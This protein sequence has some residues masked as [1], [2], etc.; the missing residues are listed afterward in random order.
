MACSAL[1][2]SLKCT[3]SPIALTAAVCFLSHEVVFAEEVVGSPGTALVTEW[4]TAGWG[5]V[6]PVPGGPVL[7]SCC[8]VAAS[9]LLVH[10]PQ[11]EG[12]A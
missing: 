3:L 5:K 11:L 7:S 8:V 1:T 9:Y 6:P 10:S 2:W 12:E 4:V